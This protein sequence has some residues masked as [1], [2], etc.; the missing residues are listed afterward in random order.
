VVKIKKKHYKHLGSIEPEAKGGKGRQR[1]PKGA[2][3]SQRKGRTFEK[4][5]RKEIEFSKWFRQGREKRK[6]SRKNIGTTGGKLLPSLI[7]T[8]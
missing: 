4:Y 2:K 7:K 1:E 3:G 5:Y 8:A 6:V